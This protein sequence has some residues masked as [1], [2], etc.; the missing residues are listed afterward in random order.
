MSAIALNKNVMKSSS[1]RILNFSL[2]KQEKFSVREE[3]DF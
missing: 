2:R 1:H 3:R